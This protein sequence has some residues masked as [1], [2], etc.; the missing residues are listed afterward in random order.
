MS[1]KSA[2]RINRTALIAVA[3]MALAPAA[4]S[5]API[6]FFGED[7]NTTQPNFPGDDPIV[8]P[9]AGSNSLAARNLFAA[10]V[11]TID[12]ETFESFNL[13]SSPSLLHFAGDQAV[14]TGTPRT[15]YNVTSPHGTM[16]GTYPT[17]GAKFLISAANS[18]G[19]TL[20]FDTAQAAFGFY[21]T[22]IGDGG[23]RL[24]LEFIGANGVSHQE[25]P[26]MAGVLN[27]GSR[28]FFGYI[29]TAATFTQV[30]FLYSS[31]SGDGFGL[32]DLMVGRAAV[33]IDPSVP[34]PASV[35]IAALGG[36]AAL[37]RRRR[38]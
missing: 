21:A 11:P 10:Q 22:D 28:F 9:L 32:D 20:T 38:S 23:G 29:D 16:N 25:V 35:A 7:V 5:A 18:G 26:S 2:T 1:R 17:S 30:R 24:R 12:V 34:E 37:V 36:A 4:A 15:I 13:G 27:S 3:S 19:L 6:T 31:S 8:I 33:V 14:L